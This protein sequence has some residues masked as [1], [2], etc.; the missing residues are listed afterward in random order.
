MPPSR[1][2]IDNGVSSRVLGKTVSNPLERAP[3]VPVDLEVAR[4]KWALLESH[5]VARAADHE[6]REL[7]EPLLCEASLLRALIDVGGGIKRQPLV[8]AVA[9]IL[10]GQA[11]ARSAFSHFS[12]SELDLTLRGGAT[13]VSVQ[14]GRALTN[15]GGVIAL[16]AAS[17]AP[18]VRQLLLL[19]PERYKGSVTASRVLQQLLELRDAP[20]V[21]LDLDTVVLHAY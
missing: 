8:E 4:L 13:A 17:A 20:G 21:T 3:A 14:A 5:D 6:L 15:N 19:V 1:R 9:D 12:A 16:L 18:A 2:M 11:V 10:G 7:V